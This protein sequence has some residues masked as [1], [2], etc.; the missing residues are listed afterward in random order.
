[1]TNTM[2]IGYFPKQKLE[3][4]PQNS[5]SSLSTQDGHHPQVGKPET[6]KRI[7]DKGALFCPPWENQLVNSHC[8]EQQSE[9]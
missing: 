9:A 6:L 7:L 4:T 3:T 5:V 8:E 2:S 1:M